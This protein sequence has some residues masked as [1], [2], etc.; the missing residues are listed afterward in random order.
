MLSAGDGCGG[1]TAQRTDGT[2]TDRTERPFPPSV[3]SAPGG[4]GVTVHI[5][6]VR[7][8]ESLLAHHNYFPTAVSRI[9]S[10]QT[11][12]GVNGDAII[13]GRGFDTHRTDG[14]G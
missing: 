4:A 8:F 6:E 9:Y 11:A 14:G 10:G 7:G 3:R 12:V 13:I 2:S 5:R 1:M